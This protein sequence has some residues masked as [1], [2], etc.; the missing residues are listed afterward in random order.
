MKTAVESGTDA[1]RTKSSPGK[2]K[3][4]RTTKN[5]CERCEGQDGEETEREFQYRH[6]EYLQHPEDFESGILQVSEHWRMMIIE[7]YEATA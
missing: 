2:R 6:L 4:G 1:V 5:L 3:K 7:S